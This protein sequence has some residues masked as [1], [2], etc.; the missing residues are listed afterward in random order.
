MLYNWCVWTN[1][2]YDLCPSLCHH[3]EYFQKS[4][5]LHLV[6]PPTPDNH[7][8]FIVPIVLPFPECHIVGIIQYIA[9]SDWLL[10]LLSN[11]HLRF[12]HVFPW[13]NSYFFLFLPVLD[14]CCYTRAFSSCGEWGLLS[15]CGVQASH[16]GNFSCS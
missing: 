5:V 15:S 14:L 2:L 11:M 13:L 7:S 8:S 1:V 16:C 3:P 6:I 4:S 9:F 10:T 12:L